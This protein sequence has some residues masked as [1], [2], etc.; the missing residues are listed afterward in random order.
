MMPF[1]D[2]LEPEAKEIGS[3]NTIILERNAVTGN[4]DLVGQNYDWQGVRNSIR[5]ALPPSIQSNPHPFGPSKC[6]FII[7]GGGTTRAAVFALSNLGLSPI[8]LINRDQSETAAVVEHFPQY[9]LRPLLSP[10]EWKEEWQD[11]V[12]CGV[13]AIPS[14]VPVTDA[15]KNVYAIAH[16]IFDGKNSDGRERYLLEMCYKVRF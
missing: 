2:R 4:I 15:E 13:G 6:T 12:A 14:F 8:F 3:I 11:K 7:G 9:D 16:K 5:S 1:V 10:E